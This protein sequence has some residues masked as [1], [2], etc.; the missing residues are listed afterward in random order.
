MDVAEA[1]VAIIVVIIGL[2]TLA[3][4]VYFLVRTIQAFDRFERVENILVRI[5]KQLNGYETEEECEYKKEAENLKKKLE[6]IRKNYDLE[7]E[8]F[9]FD[10]SEFDE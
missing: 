2:A 9:I 4:E 6:F 8:E 10:S 7:D 5:S 3:L 1:I